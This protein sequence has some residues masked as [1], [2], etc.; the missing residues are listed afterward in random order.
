MLLDTT[1]DALGWPARNEV[2]TPPGAGPGVI[3][4]LAK[5]KIERTVVRLED[6]AGARIGIL[7]ANPRAAATEAPIA[8]VCEFPRNVSRRTLLETRR[9][10]WNFC[11]S[12]LLI[13]L[14]P[15]LIRSWTCCEPPIQADAPS[16]FDTATPPGLLAE[17]APDAGSLASQ[18]A[19][20]FQW[21][22]LVS[23]GAA[24]LTKTACTGTSVRITCC[25]R[26]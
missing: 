21:V 2:L 19:Q 9:L 5:A 1:H 16:L 8:V 20:A 10:A 13:T 26:I 11:R 24:A 18:A 6:G 22:E 3:A 12:P 15:T 17:I 25:L 4:D 7:T 23:G 14:E